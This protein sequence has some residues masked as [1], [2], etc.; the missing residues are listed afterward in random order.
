MVCVWPILWTFMQL[1]AYTPSVAVVAG[2]GLNG[3]AMGALFYCAC[4]IAVDRRAGFLASAL[5]IA[6]FFATEHIKSTHDRATVVL[7][8]LVVNAVCWAAQIFGH[9]AF[10]GRAP[11]LLDNLLVA[12]VIAP[13]F[14]LLECI[15]H[16]G[17]EPE[18]GFF[19][20]T[21]ARVARL[22][23]EYKSSKAKRT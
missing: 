5:V 19:A 14:V 23:A 10:E 22:V 20:R 3:A 15:M 7:A 4:Y 8:S 12:F 9:Q 1:L 17:Y 13:Y 11:A 16:L 2:I 21:D 18:P 6:G